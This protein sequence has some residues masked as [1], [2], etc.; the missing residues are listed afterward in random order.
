MA[1]WTEMIIESTT[2]HLVTAKDWNDFISTLTLWR[3]N[4]SKIQVSTYLED[5]ALDESISAE[6]K[7][8]TLSDLA[9]RFLERV[10]EA[11]EE[12]SYLGEA[13]VECFTDQ[14]ASEVSILTLPRSHDETD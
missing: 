6:I 2:T 13:I 9:G 14:A 11:G 4:H 10:A 5:L 8:V 12:E 3:L 7:A 1:D